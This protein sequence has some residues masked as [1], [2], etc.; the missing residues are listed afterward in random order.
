MKELDLRAGPFV[1]TLI[2]LSLP[3]MAG[4]FFNLLY[5]LVDTWF[6]AQLDPMDP[7]LVGS[8]GLV[9]PLMIIFWAV[10]MGISGGIASLVAR[11]IGSGNTTELDRVAESG[12]AMAGMATLG[13][14]AVLYPFSSSVLQVF[15][16]QGPMLA[17]AEEY[18][19]WLLPMVPFLFLGSVFS[20]ILQ[21]EGRT[22]HL[23]TS[24]I[25]GAISNMILDPVLMFGLGMGIAGAGLATAIGNGL[26][27]VY[28]FVVLLRSQ[29]QVRIHWRLSSISWPIMGEITR[30]GLPQSLGNLLGSLSFLFY[31]RMISDLNPILLSAF[32]LYSRLEQI[33]LI[34]IFSLSSGLGTLAGHAAGAGNISRFRQG[35]STSTLLAMVSGGLLLLAYVL[36]SSWLF[37]I[38]QGNRM[39]LD[40]A[41]QITPWMAFSTLVFIPVIMANAIFSAAGFSNRGLVLTALR[42][43]ALNIPAAF[44][45]A[46]VWG[47]STEGV[48][49]GLAL[50][51]VLALFLTLVVVLRFMKALESGKLKIRA[52][53]SP[54]TAQTV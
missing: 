13:I 14:L 31:N 44:L 39:V 53:I 37:G 47:K 41:S 23:M 30:V 12:L 9:F 24:M 43:Y 10:G 49:V 3:V 27:T 22:K 52:G 25:I 40:L 45:G 34:P 11:A 18:L 20:G 51:S 35:F 21:G 7:Y 48:M 29:H 26:G 8:T 1:P 33:A 54:E 6:I 16:G 36:L 19:V 42:I 2:K 38:F 28:L 15:G 4:Q 32:T 50:S 5:N 46:Y 17:Y